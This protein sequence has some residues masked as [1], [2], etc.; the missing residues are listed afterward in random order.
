MAALYD[1]SVIMV[2]QV[3]TRDLVPC[4]CRMHGERE[5]PLH[6]STV[7]EVCKVRIASMLP[8]DACAVIRKIYSAILQELLLFFITPV[9]EVT[10]PRKL[11]T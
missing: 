1:T 8:V 5:L 4:L 7:R 9:G 10:R 6:L 3:S 11:K 2:S